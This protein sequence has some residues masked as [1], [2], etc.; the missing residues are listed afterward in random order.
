[1][2]R[3]TF[4]APLKSVFNIPETEARGDALESRLALA[5]RARLSRLRDSRPSRRSS[6]AFFSARAFWNRRALLASSS[7][8]LLGGIAARGAN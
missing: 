3:P 2:A 6:L 7:S 5:R 1:L 8:S 4:G